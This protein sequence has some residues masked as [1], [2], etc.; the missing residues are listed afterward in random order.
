MKSTADHK[1]EKGV[2]FFAQLLKSPATIG[3]VAPSSTQLAKS[4][5]ETV[6]FNTVKT[7]VEFGPGTG[8]FS[9]QIL[10][11]IKPSSTY[12]ALEVNGVMVDHLKKTIP[13]L[14]VY[15]DSADRTIEYL[16]KHS[17]MHADV[18]I[19]GL[20]WAAF[21]DKL[22][23]ELLDV[24]IKALPVGGLFITF[25]YL[26]GLILPAGKKF[27][28]KLKQNFSKIRRSGVVWRNLPPA[29]IYRCTK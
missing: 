22:Q 7:I 5:L 19:S 24:T 17:S 23:D 1:T 21:D 26:N 16:N 29:I 25:A 6:D 9:G 13:E 2:N 3:A 11:S 4:M 14:T 15:H 28:R 12:F 27:Y 10:K 8:V 18:I 20:P